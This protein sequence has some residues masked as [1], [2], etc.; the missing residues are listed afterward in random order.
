MMMWVFYL[1]PLNVVSVD[2]SSTGSMH[3]YSVK[4]N[5]AITSVKCCFS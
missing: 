3:L 4:K 5:K 1:W 2:D